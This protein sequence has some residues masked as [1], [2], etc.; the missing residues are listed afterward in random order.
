MWQ[1]IVF[2]PQV[3]NFLY[4]I[5]TRFRMAALSN[6]WSDARGHTTGV[7]GI[8]ELVEFI[9]YSAEIGFAKPDPRAFLYVTRKLGVRPEQTL[10]VD[11]S[12]VNVAAAEALGIHS[13]RCLDP[14]QMIRDV[15]VALTT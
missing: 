4:R 1:G 11:D 7:Y 3:A 2:L 13:V 12:P 8:E 5:K 10:F 14:E 9:A 6:A 15:E